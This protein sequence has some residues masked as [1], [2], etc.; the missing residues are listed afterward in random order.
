[1]R[2]VYL[3][4]HS[5]T[6]A[7]EHRLYCGRTDLPLS[8]AGRVLA[9]EARGALALPERALCVTSG[10]RRADETLTL[11]TGLSADAVL[12]DLR[13]TDFGAFEM[14]GYDDL[15]GDD[16]YRRW[17]GDATG[18]IACPGGESRDAFR[19]RARRGGA[20]LL[21]MGGDVLAVCH[22]GVIVALMQAWFPDEGRHFYQWQPEPCR[23]YRV[24]CDG[25]RPVSFE[26]V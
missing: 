7:N 19:A 12:P 4:R 23:G 24:D 16:A 15:R 8:P 10:M 20:A 13:E 18:A 22:G 26:E 14:R 25:M 17:I 21:R 9:L 5:L 3:L 2:L 11:L 1:M 6:E